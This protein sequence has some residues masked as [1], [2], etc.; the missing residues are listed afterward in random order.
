MTNYALSILGIIPARYSSNRLPGKVL[1]D[2]NGKPMLQRVWEAAC[3][4]KFLSRIIIATDDERI[5]NL[6]LNIGAEY[7]MT[8]SELSSGT[9]RAIYAYRILNED[10]EIILNIQ[11]DEP[12]LN[13]PLIDHL[14]ESFIA[15]NADVGTLIKRIDNNEDIFN[16]SVV[17]VTLNN[18]SNA[19]YFSRSPI[20]YLRDYPK[21]DWHKVHT[22]WKHIGIYIYK[23]TA[24]L[25]F[26]VLA[27]S[28]LDKFEQL[29]Q[30]R[31]L[32]NG[33]SIHCI[34]TDQN[35]ISID[36]YEDLEHIKN[37]LNQNQK[38]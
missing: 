15:R 33:Y 5:E 25:N 13:G 38:H 34:E 7:I 37:Y 3:R 4:S 2:I 21:S 20:P 29:E 31:F 35:L 28:E 6:C 8:P 22:F 14:I 36:T 9:E 26:N 23:H 12:L 18:E 24:F 19:L 11:G 17:K 30:L 32:Q 1:A 27:N 10:S 16:P